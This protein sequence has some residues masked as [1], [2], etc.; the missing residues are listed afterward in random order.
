MIR[1]IILENFMA[2]GRTEL[3][4][5]PGVTVLAGPNNVGKSAVVEALRCLSLNPPAQGFIRHGAKEARVEV[6]LDEG[7][8]V[9]RR[10]ATNAS[11]ELRQPRSSE[12]EEYHKLGKNS[13][14]E[15]VQKILR[16]NK[17][18]VEGVSGGLDVHLGD[19]RE[20]IFLLNLSG[21]AQAGFF[22]ASSE[23]AH[24]LNMQNLL[25]TR[26]REAKDREKAGRERLDRLA[27][28]LDRLSALPGLKISMDVAAGFLS[29]L[30]ELGRE[31]PILEGRI[32]SLRRLAGKRLA[33]LQ[34]EERLRPL[35]GP[36]QLQE[37]GSLDSSIGGLRSAIR[38]LALAQRLRQALSPL[39]QAPTL[40]DVA[41]L[42][43]AAAGLR[44]AIRTQAFTRRLGQALSPLRQAPTLVDVAPLLGTSAGLRRKL[45]ALQ[46]EGARHAALA[47]LRPATEMQATEGLASLAM[48]LRETGRRKAV[49]S[50]RLE[51]LARTA[52]APEPMAKA[53]LESCAARLR[54]ALERR[55]KLAR[56]LA[57]R[58][59]ELRDM[60]E[61]VRQR[62]EALGACPLCGAELDSGRFLGRTHGAA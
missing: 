1:K 4:L 25:K 57:E 19:Q 13:V 28:V 60:E 3:P 32:A 5:G 27:G 11:Y 59:E 50:R 30:E 41:P 29:S 24:L 45:A 26:V 9:W 39:R 36:P 31:L 8:V 48:R 17:V 7:S 61:R 21:S 15:D 16:L 20:P 34:E 2:H 55:E 54:E 12:A 38:T 22:A 44:S 35:S 23:A 46:A 10:K 49:E 37:T 40:V 52:K 47:G 18:E 43:G 53:G 51:I 56:E 6:E 58:T 42:L 14:P 33:F 62:L